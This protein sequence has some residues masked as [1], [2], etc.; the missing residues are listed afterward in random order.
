MCGFVGFLS[1]DRPVGE[2]NIDIRAGM[3]ALRHRGPDG[4]GFFESP[5]GTFQVGFR[6]LSVIDLENS[7]Q[8]IVSARDGRILVGNGEIYN[9]VELRER[10]R[11]F[12]YRSA[13]D[14]ETVLAAID[15][16]GDDFVHDLTGMFALGIFEPSA[17]R[18]TLVRDHTGVKPLYWVRRYDGG[19]G[20]ASEIKALFA[21]G[22]VEPEIDR[23]Q[24]AQYLSHGYV[25]GPATLFSGIMKLRPGCCLHVS[26]G[27]VANKRYWFPG[28]SRATISSP[29][30]LRENLTEKLRNSVRLNM[31]SDVPVGAL[32]SG[33]LDSGLLVAFASEFASRALTTLTVN[34]E[35]ADYDESGL[36]RAVAER[37]GTNHK[38]VLVG[39]DTVDREL[40]DA[41]WHLEEPLYDAALLPNHII[42][43]EMSQYAKVS[44]NGTGGDELFAGYRRY[45][46]LPIE[47]RYLHLPAPIRNNVA[48]PLLGMFSPMM[49]WKLGRAEKFNTDP[50]GYLFDHST[51]FPTPILGLIDYQGGPTPSVQSGYFEEFDGERQSGMLYADI[52][53]YL[54]DDLLTLLDRT[55]MAVGV[56]GRVPFL[57]HALVELAL[58]AP[59]AVRS[60]NKSAK[61][62]EREIAAAYLPEAVLRAPKQGFTSPVPA[63]M[64]GPIRDSVKNLLQRPAA[65]SRKWWSEEG[66]N[67]LFADTR[68]HGYRIYALLILELVTTL[69]VDERCFEDAPGVALNEFSQSV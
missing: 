15:A 13:G 28:Q 4:V 24:V 33:G 69:Y 2:L 41:V 63:W 32:L 11:D 55:S 47:R 25:P 58:S 21:A 29:D 39:L 40:I 14:I 7:P 1:V 45:F 23:S 34:F 66:I 38:E 46:Q 9:F 65:L 35:G 68:A 8:P 5:D 19:V 44:L 53:S 54:C 10:Y 67:R 60:P 16:K 52:K 51:Q 37:Y 30:E 31:Q 48:Q 49:A 22:I 27:V 43:K 20:F 56:E 57:D 3:R 61:H 42:Q 6:R 12:P 17:R 18:L 50:G 59:E 62:L 36:A 64:Q 26:D